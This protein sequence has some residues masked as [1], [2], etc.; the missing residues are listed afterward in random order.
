MA[1]EPDI[2][3]IFELNTIS[4]KSA[5]RDGKFL[6]FVLGKGFKEFKREQETTIRLMNLETK[7]EETISEPKT[8]FSQPDFSGDG[9]YLSY[10]S[11]REN[12]FHITIR[13]LRAQTQMAIKCP[14]PVVS[15]RWGKAQK[16][17]M[18]VSPPTQ[19]P[20]ASEK[21]DDGYFFEDEE[22]KNSLLILDF[23]N[24]FREI[25]GLPQIWEFD[26]DGNTIVAVA[27]DSPREGSWFS[28][29]LLGISEEGK[30]EKIYTPEK[31]QV[32]L[33][34]ISPDGKSISFIESMWSDRGV[35]SGDLMVLERSN[36][37][38]SNLSKGEEAS[39]S[40]SIWL[41]ENVL[42]GLCQERDVFVIRKYSNM[43]GEVIWRKRGSIGPGM[44]PEMKYGRNKIYLDLSNADLPQEILSIDL[45]SSEENTVTSVNETAKDFVKYRW[46]SIKWNSEDGMEVEGFLRNPGNNRPLLVVV[47]GGPTG[48]VKETYMDRYSYLLPRGYSIFM[49]NFRGST[50]RGR[51]F[52]RLN[53]GDMGGMDLKDIL[54]GVENL[55][56]TGKVDRNRIAITGG[57]Y[58]GFMTQWAVTQSKLFRCAI[59]LF[60]ISD[61]VS[62]HGTT[63]IPEW[64]EMQYGESPYKFNKFVY[65]S[66]IR[67]VKN[68]EAKLIIMHGEADPCVPPN[69]SYQFYRALKEQGKD[70]KL[71]L[72]PREGHGFSERDHIRKS[73]E[74]TLKILEENLN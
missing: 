13:N 67:Y 22:K 52:A 4:G 21:A 5:S 6:A 54:Y 44:A 45:N 73:M 55:I 53:D 12:N 14:G 18:L 39:Y 31:A 37:R 26:Y 48:S 11:S 49:P 2:N 10:I 70:V 32:A 29:Y 68:I 63:N 66:P 56:Q 15:Y 51:K 35:T 43:Q 42:L 25:K 57:S 59:A 38:V 34:V 60:G 74:E 61:W 62:F 16:I 33:P 65:F 58:G 46:E 41:E 72:F 50:G 23:E 36:S 71:L 9:E 8:S 30:F 3:S 47:H 64:D 17:A 28:S 27:S 20:S 40:S 7:S 19:D 24:G 69:Q 1:R